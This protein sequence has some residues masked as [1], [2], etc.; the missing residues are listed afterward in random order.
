[1]SQ[2]ISILNQDMFNVPTE[3]LKC[4]KTVID[5]HLT[6]SVRSA[7]FKKRSLRVKVREEIC[8]R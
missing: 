2:I 4:Q 8:L 5:Q 3:N 6:I 7:V 1:M